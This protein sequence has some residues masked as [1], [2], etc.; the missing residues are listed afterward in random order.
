MFPK[1]RV[2]LPTPKQRRPLPQSIGG[3]S[4]PKAAQAPHSKKNAG[5]CPK[6]AGPPMIGGPST[7]AP[8]A[9]VFP[10][11]PRPQTGEGPGVPKT[12]KAPAPKAAEAP[13][14]PE[15]QG[16]LPES[17]GGPPLPKPKR[18]PPQSGR[19]RRV[20]KAHKAPLLKRWRPHCSRSSGGPYPK[21]VEAPAPAFPKRHRPQ[22]SQNGGGPLPRAAVATMI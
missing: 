8:Q 15:R 3:H 13:P 1:Q 10:N 5:R 12:A 21:A 4:V 11:Q 2:P 14:F 22:C 16:P 7:K 18:H 6:A 19:G 9:T 20:P 17:A